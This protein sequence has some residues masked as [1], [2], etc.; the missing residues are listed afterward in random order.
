MNVFDTGGH[1]IGRF[2]SGGVLNSP[3][4][5]AM[6]PRGFGAFGGD[7]LIGNFGDGRINAFDP[8]TGV[9]LGTVNDT[10]GFPVSIRGLWALAFGN[11]GNGGD[12]HTLYFTAG[13][14]GENDGL[15][16]SF[17]AESPVFTSITNDGI[18]VSVSWGGPL[19]A[20]KE[21]RPVRYQL[22]QF[23]NDSRPQP[24]HP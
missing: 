6:A 2:A 11:G 9:W 10:N 5:V 17:L 1:L 21:V 16:G 19:P 15:F 20:A 8:A 23:A 12:T 24:A 4:G 13:L 14:N 18:A 3:W 22:D 7:L